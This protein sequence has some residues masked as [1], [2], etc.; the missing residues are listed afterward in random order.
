SPATTETD[1]DQCRDE[2]WPPRSPALRRSARRPVL[3]RSSMPA[4]STDC[5]LRSSR[6]PPARRPEPSGRRPRGCSSPDAAGSLY[7]LVQ[8]L[9]DLVHGEKA[10]TLALGFC[11][12]QHGQKFT[13]LLFDLL[14]QPQRR[15]G[16]LADAVVA[17]APH[18]AL[19]EA[20]QF[21]GK[22]DVGH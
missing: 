17:S 13:T 21:R 14:Q 1:A 15:A 19:S 9:H 2:A 12:L 18:A 3:W 6:R 22:A 20:L 10:V 8:V 4:R 7:G 11:R 5:P 16:H